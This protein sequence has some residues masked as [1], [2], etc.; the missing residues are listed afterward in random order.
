MAVLNTLVYHPNNTLEEN[1]Y[2]GTGS[3]VLMYVMCTTSCGDVHNSKSEH[4]GIEEIG[5]VMHSQQHSNIR[6]HAYTNL[7]I[8]H[9]VDFAEEEYEK[10]SLA[11]G[12][13]ARAGQGSKLCVFLYDETNP[14]NCFVQIFEYVSFASF[15]KRVENQTI[16]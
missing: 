12:F 2:P 9:E 8:V 15:Y 10:L 5:Q 6:Y 11:I 16:N 7:P 13:C 14:Y 1:A 3:I 4:V